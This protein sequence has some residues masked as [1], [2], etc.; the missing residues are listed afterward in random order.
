MLVEEFN[1]IRNLC[2]LYKYIIESYVKK[3]SQVTLDG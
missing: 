3:L 1:F 2:K